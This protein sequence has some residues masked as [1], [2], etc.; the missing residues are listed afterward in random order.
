MPRVNL[1]RSVLWSWTKFSS[2]ILTVH[3]GKP[4]KL[5]MLG[6]FYNM[7]ESTYGLYSVIRIKEVTLFT[8]LELYSLQK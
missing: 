7:R 5:P 1:M 2:A 3:V 8:D 6:A 4:N